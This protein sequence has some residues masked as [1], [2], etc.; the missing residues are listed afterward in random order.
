MSEPSLLL[1]PF[2]DDDEDVRLVQRYASAG[3]RAGAR[4]GSAPGPVGAGGGAGAGAAA[5][6]LVGHGVTAVDPSDRHAG[7]GSAHEASSPHDD[8]PV[9]IT[10]TE[11]SPDADG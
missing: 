5:G 3:P 6:F 1:E 2:L 9:T 7:E 4:V 10:V 8:G 11:A